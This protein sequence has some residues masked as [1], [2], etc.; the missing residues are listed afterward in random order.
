MD[1]I[2]IKLNTFNKQYYHQ[3]TYQNGYKI[4]CHC[5]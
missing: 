3:K 1:N 5:N 4:K 2:G